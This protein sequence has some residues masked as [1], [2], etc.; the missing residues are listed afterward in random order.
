LIGAGVVVIVV[1]LLLMMIRGATKAAEKAEAILG[2]LDEA[3]VN[4]AALWEVDTTN[5]V[6]DRIVDSAT[7]AREYLQSTAAR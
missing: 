2:A 4:T 1:V 7:S 6:A 5:Q 3:Q